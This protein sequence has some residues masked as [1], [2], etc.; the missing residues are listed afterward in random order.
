M[1]AT[2]RNIRSSRSPGLSTSWCL[3][4]AR[5]VTAMSPDGLCVPDPEGLSGAMLNLCL[6]GR[7]PYT[8]CTK[9]T[10]CTRQ[11]ASSNVIPLQLSHHQALAAATSGPAAALL[12]A[13]AE[14]RQGVDHAGGDRIALRGASRRLQQGRP[15]DAGIPLAQS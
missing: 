9:S 11:R 6:D 5:M 1:R 7:R 10:I 15:E 12:T 14:W 8:H 13:D 3:S 2:P 4:A